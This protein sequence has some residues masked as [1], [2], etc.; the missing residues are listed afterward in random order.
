MWENIITIHQKVRIKKH[1]KFHYIQANNTQ[2]INNRNPANE[3]EITAII[4]FET[5]SASKTALLLSH[6]MINDHAIKVNLCDDDY[7]NNN[8]IIEKKEENLIKNIEISP[9][10]SSTGILINFDGIEVDDIEDTIE[11]KEIPQN[12]LRSSTVIIF[13]N[14][15]EL[16]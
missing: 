6:A 16:I 1:K 3:N 15:S 2:I 8:F 11:I 4:H 9:P 14:I 13:L 12:N 5:E 7:N 10:Q